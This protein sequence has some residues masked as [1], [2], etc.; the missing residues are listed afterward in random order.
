[1]RILK[2]KILGN[3]DK[4]GENFKN[5]CLQKKSNFFKLS[6]FALKKVITFKRV[7]SAKSLLPQGTALELLT[8]SRSSKAEISR[9]TKSFLYMFIT[10]RFSDGGLE[11]I[12]A[13]WTLLQAPSMSCIQSNFAFSSSGNTHLFGLFNEVISMY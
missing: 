12:I 1:M 10:S 8:W 5:L 11:K 9:Q 13:N 2:R 6:N 7:Q 3:F 4:G